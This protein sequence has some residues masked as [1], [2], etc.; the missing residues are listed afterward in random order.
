M[1]EDA[2]THVNDVLHSFR[3]KAVELGDQINF[4]AIVEAFDKP[5]T[6]VNYP[7]HIPRKLS[8]IPN[9]VETELN[10]LPANERD[11]ATLE[12]FCE[13]G[14]TPGVNQVVTFYIS[15]NHPQTSEEAAHQCMLSKA[16]SGVIALID[17][18]GI[19]PDCKCL[20]CGSD[21]Y[22]LPADDALCDELSL[23]E[24][25]FDRW[26]ICRSPHC[27]TQAG[28]SIG[29]EGVDWLVTAPSGP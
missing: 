6:T 23:V 4:S 11:S 24:E 18:S 19:P 16:H 14:Y 9:W 15:A 1:N 20:F 25:N 2:K 27:V 3:K 29:Q 28:E 13:Y 21:A 26:A 10:K 7:T 8:D 22:D 17:S 5:R 12:S